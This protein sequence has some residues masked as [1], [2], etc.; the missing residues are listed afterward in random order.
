M[1]VNRHYVYRM[2]DANANRAMEGLRVAEDFVRFGLGNK[3]W[4]ADFKV[5]RHSLVNELLKLPVPVSARLLSRDSRHDVGRK[6]G[7]LALKT[8]HEV[9]TENLKRAQESL[10]VIEETARTLQPSS[11][12]AF[13]NLRFQVYELEKEVIPLFHKTFREKQKIKGVYFVAD[14]ES[15]GEKRFL[16]VVR[17]SLQAGVDVIQLRWTGIHLHTVVSLGRRVKQQAEKYGAPFLI[18]DRVD[19]AAAVGAD[20]VH[21]G[22]CDMPLTAARKILGPDKIIG[23]S[24]HSVAEA[25][26]AEREGADYVAVGPVFPT[27]T[28]EDAHPVVGVRGVRRLKENVS[29]P[30]VAI[31]GIHEDNV[32]AVVKEGKAD[33]VAV[34]SAITK[35]RNVHL[36]V[37]NL[38]K[39]F[40]V[41]L[42]FIFMVRGSLLM[43]SDFQS[44]FQK[45]RE[46]SSQ[47]RFVEAG[48]AFQSL[49]SSAPSTEEFQQASLEYAF[50][51]ERLGK[52]QDEEDTLKKAFNAAKNTP[53]SASLCYNLGSLYYRLGRFQEAGETFSSCL[54]LFPKHPN[55]FSMRM[56]LA[57]IM[58]REGKIDESASLLQKLLKDA[59]QEN[60]RMAARSALLDFYARTKNYADAKTMLETEVKKSPDDVS[61][62]LQLAETDEKLQDYAGALSVYEKLDKMAPELAFQRKLFVLKK[63]NRLSSEEEKLQSQLLQQKTALLFLRLAQV[64]EMDGKFSESLDLVEKARKLFP[65]DEGVLT[66]LARLYQQNKDYEKALDIEHVL[67]AQHPGNFSYYKSMGEIYA[68]AGQKKEAV[69]AWKKFFIFNPKDANSVFTFASFLHDQSMYEDALEI[70]REG[71]KAAGDEFLFAQPMAQLYR[72]LLKKEG[73]VDECVKWLVKDT[74]SWDAAAAFM[75]SAGLSDADRQEAIEKLLS[76]YEKFPSS[77]SLYKAASL[78]ALKSNNVQKAYDIAFAAIKEPQESCLFLFSL[79]QN[80][81]GS[82]AGDDAK[83]SS[84]EILLSKCENVP[85]YGNMTL[86]F[87]RQLMAQNRYPQSQKFLERVLT[88][89]MK[90]NERASL[91]QLLAESY[92][93]NGLALKARE[94]YEKIL[95]RSGMTPSASVYFDYGELLFNQGDYKKSLL[96][97]EKAGASGFL[98]QDALLFYRGAC[99]YFQEKFDESSSDFENLISLYPQSEYANDALLRLNILKNG[100]PENIKLLADAEKA[101]NAARLEEAETQLL[102]FISQRADSAL[103]LQAHFLLGENYEK[104][105]DAKNAVAVYQKMLSSFEEGAWTDMLR[106]KIKKLMEMGKG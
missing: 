30:V 9:L 1:S 62:A 28:K 24:T 36:T 76:Y 83:F 23:I 97:F 20:G 14:V 69:E 41:A 70:Y 12:Q 26:K 19:V 45:A 42:I 94:L 99:A 106:E 100:E 44:E 102:S 7:S 93:K 61:L 68:S 64:F 15:A 59:A 25:K 47:G 101:Q 38:K 16:S 75:G 88:K 98:Q 72:I 65:Y 50:V 78:L 63:L 48:G 4:A 3:K 39:V 6:S 53:P 8:Q 71:R 10:R 18:N 17:Q 56:M 57:Q 96:F 80:Q 43:A 13:E 33:A 66:K 89:T 67:L 105:H 81:P 95:S 104:K 32:R 84:A 27:Q 103:L 31:G 79:M 91:E 90:E 82:G 34:I 52:F 74:N 2:L 73:V 58:E 55:N 35:S 60:E 46:L 86:N 29:L 77:V 85:S 37:K 5:I 49:L 21:L 40:L 87:A 54:A 22:Q 11:L 92:E 51:L